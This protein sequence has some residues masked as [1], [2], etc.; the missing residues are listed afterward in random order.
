MFS[1]F[2]IRFRQNG[3]SDTVSISWK[4]QKCF[5]KSRLNF[6]PIFLNEQLFYLSISSDFL[7]DQ[8]S[9]K[10]QFSGRKIKRISPKNYPLKSS[11]GIF[12]GLQMTVKRD[13]SY[14]YLEVCLDSSFIVNSPF[15]FPDGFDDLKYCQFDYGKTLDIL[16]TPQV[17]FTDE[18]LISVAP[19]KRNCFF[20]G[21]RELK[22]FKTYTKLSCEMECYSD[23]LFRSI[24]CTPFYFARVESMEV[25]DLALIKRIIGRANSTEIQQCN[26]LEPCNLVKYEIEIV[27]NWLKASTNES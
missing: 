27:Q 13:L 15:E 9:V 24:N 19:E 22:F 6:I 16:I 3:D 23:Y 10:T 1:Q 14:R 4:D 5:V 25:C 26:C 17:I 21:E 11:G 2:F 7:Y 12:E 18:N 20:D 8:Y